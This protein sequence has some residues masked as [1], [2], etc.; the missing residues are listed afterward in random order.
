MWHLNANSMHFFRTRSQRFQDRPPS[1]HIYAR[2]YR[3]VF[4]LDLPTCIRKLFAPL[5]TRLAWD[6]HITKLF[7]WPPV[8]FT[9]CDHSLWTKNCRAQNCCC[10]FSMGQCSP[11]P[12]LIPRLLCVAGMSP[13]P[14]CTL[15]TVLRHLSGGI[16][17]K[18]LNVT[19]NDP[20][21]LCY[22]NAVHQIRHLDTS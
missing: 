9:C 22:E 12:F 1:F 10:P 11:P 7:R 8:H 6:T 2:I 13:W 19:L 18:I 3:P 15:L 16:S 4:K 17:N 5:K 14:L 20:G 21:W